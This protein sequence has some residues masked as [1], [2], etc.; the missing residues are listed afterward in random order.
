MGWMIGTEDNK[1]FAH[2]LGPSDLLFDHIHTGS[3]VFFPFDLC[4]VWLVFAAVKG[5][6]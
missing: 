6:S 5:Q 4:E 2:D 3:G 1:I